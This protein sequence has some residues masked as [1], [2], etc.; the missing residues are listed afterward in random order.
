MIIAVDGPAGAG[1]GSL[2]GALEK[3][4]GFA[5]LDTGLLYRAVGLKVLRDGDDPENAAAA[6]AAATSL[7]FDELTDPMLRSD[8]AG[9]AAS[10]VGAIPGVRAAL[11]DFQ[12]DFANNPPGGAKGAIL[13]GRDIGTAVCP[14]AEI[15]LFITASTEIRAKRRY[16]EL[17]DR[18][19]EAIYATVFDDMKQ[20]DERDSGRS[21]APMTKADD[22]FLL[23]TDAMDIPTVVAAA[24]NFIESKTS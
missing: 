16:K 4:F 9:Q 7:Q 23:E 13:D 14:N 20:R 24:L 19:H 1:K 22:A 8:D 2:C 3:H 18:G 11:L 15:K 17:L 21:S 6:E 10:K 5:K 12:R